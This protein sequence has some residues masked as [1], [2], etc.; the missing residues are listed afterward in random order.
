VSAKLDPRKSC[1]ASD[2]STCGASGQGC[3]GAGHCALW[4][5]RTLC[6]TDHCANGVA[7]HFVCDGAG[8]C[9]G[10]NVN[11]GAY[12]CAAN[13]CGAV[14][15]RDDQCA[16]GVVCDTGSHTCVSATRC[17]SDHEQQN[18]D[19]T[20]TDCG[21]YRC[22]GVTC[23]AQCASVDDCVTGLVCDRGAHCV[24]PPSNAA[25]DSGGCAMTETRL[26]RG[27]FRFAVP[28]ATIAALASALRRRR[29]S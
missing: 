11:C 14:C 21:G 24:Q 17:A 22:Q 29:R 7:T 19:G 12:A 8:Q 20:T 10:H 28:L 3:D 27:E 25:T 15:S 18:P 6:G 13:E 16:S 26:S 9:E 4:D 23:V 1:A 5:D 2:P